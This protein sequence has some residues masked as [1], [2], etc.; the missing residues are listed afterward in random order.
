MAYTVAAR[1]REIGIR[2]ALGA[3]PRR[4]VAAVVGDGLGITI[5]GAAV[6]FVAA[7]VSSRLMTSLLFGVTAHDAVTFIVAPASLVVVAIVAS[8]VPAARAARVDPMI[9]LRF[10]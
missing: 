6:G 7:F 4:V 9:V 1:M 3:Q 10:E 8:V 5:V 2:V